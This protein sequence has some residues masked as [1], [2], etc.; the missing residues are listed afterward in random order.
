MN[1]EL[2]AEYMNENYD[3]KYRI[4]PMLEIMD[5][6]LNDIYKSKFWGYSLPLYLSASLGCHP[7]YAIYLAEK[8]SLTEKSFRELLRGIPT[9][10]KPP[11]VRRRQSGTIGDTRRTSAMTVRRCLLW[12]NDLR[13]K[14][15]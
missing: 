2:F 5:E 15:C 4:E 10:T 8:D 6:Y 1:L 7:N 14:R 11:S 3:T 9:G 12:P 13:A